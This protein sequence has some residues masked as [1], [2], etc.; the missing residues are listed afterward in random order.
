MMRVS[1][2]FGRASALAIVASLIG[3]GSLPALAAET[4]N[5]TKTMVG[6]PKAVF[7]TVESVNVVPARARIGGTVAQAR[8]E[9]G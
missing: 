1:H 5:V 7:A 4:F 3:A 8:R 2:L 9:R 6:D